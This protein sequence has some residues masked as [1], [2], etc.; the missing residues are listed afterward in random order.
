MEMI[1]KFRFSADNNHSHL[2]K[3]EH[4]N[5]NKIGGAGKIKGP[6]VSM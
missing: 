3:F 2:R 6:F 5:P 1:G 4:K